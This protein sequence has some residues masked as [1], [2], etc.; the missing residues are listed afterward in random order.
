MFKQIKRD[1]QA[2]LEAGSG[3][4]Q[5]T[6]SFTVLFRISC[7]CSA[8]FCPLA[9]QTPTKA[10]SAYGFSIQPVLTGVKSICRQNGQ[11]LY[12]SWHGA[13]SLVKPL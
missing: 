4:T 9:A 1:I 6:G 5:C 2:V 8:S 12:R 13:W 3:R 7:R 11:G 10:D